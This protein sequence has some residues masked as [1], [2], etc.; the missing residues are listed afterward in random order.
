MGLGV[1]DKVVQG[2]ERPWGKEQIQVLECFRKKETVKAILPVC[3]AMC[4]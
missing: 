2:Q 3:V 1:E 4:V